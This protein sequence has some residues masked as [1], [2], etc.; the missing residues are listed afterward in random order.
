MNKNKKLFSLVCK[1]AES[2]DEMMEQ[3]PAI[4]HRQQK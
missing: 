1:F 4:Q 2:P 3:I